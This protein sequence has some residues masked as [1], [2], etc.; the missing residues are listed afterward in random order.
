MARQRTHNK[1]KN[2]KEINLLIKRWLDNCGC[3]LCLVIIRE[4]FGKRKTITNN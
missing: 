4:R 3:E 1:R 2:R